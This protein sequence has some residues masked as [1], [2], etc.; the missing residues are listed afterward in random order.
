MKKILIFLFSFFLFNAKAA[1]VIL[2]GLTHVHKAVKGNTVTGKIVLKNTGKKDTRIVIYRNDLTLPCNGQ[3]SYQNISSHGWSL[4]DKLKTNVDEKLLLSEEEYEV[5]YK[6]ELPS[7]LEKT[8]TYYE[9]IMVESAEPVAEEIRE[10]VKVGSKIRYA[11][12]IVLDLGDY[13]HPKVNIENIELK[14]QADLSKTLNITL[15]NNDTYGGVVSISLE[16]FDK[17]NKKIRVFDKIKRR[18]YPDVCINEDI[19]IKDLPTGKYEGVIVVD[20]GKDLIGSNLTIE[21]E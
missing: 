7:D 4:G 5:T 8:G 3:M 21:I 20:N 15:K 13:H 11:V 19:Q 6:I 12:Q 1:I 16:I 2:N 18:M 14:K 17:D 10:G 9:V